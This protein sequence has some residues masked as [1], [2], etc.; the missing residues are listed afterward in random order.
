MPSSCG[1]QPWIE[2]SLLL[3]LHLPAC[4]SYLLQSIHIKTTPMSWVCH[5][6]SHFH[7]IV[8]G[9]LVALFT[10][11][12]CSALTPAITFHLDKSPLMALP[13]ESS[14]TL[15]DHCRCLC[16]HS[17]KTHTSLRHAQSL[18]LS[19]TPC[20]PMDCSRA[21]CSVHGILQARILEWVA[22]PSSRDLSDPGT[23]PVSACISRIASGFFTHW[24]T[25]KV[26][27]QFGACSPD[28]QAYVS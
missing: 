27:Y 13:S 6:G 20:D 25:W 22:T 2:S 19:L 3:P 1:E 24:D 10:S 14:L 8:H 5:A 15:P 11:H 17:F 23:E 21:G 12:S 26:P 4:P 28:L 18:Q 7:Q 16:C 9:F